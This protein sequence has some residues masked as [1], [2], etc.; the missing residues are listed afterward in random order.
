[1]QNSYFNLPII[2]TA[3]N[4]ILGNIFP[5]KKSLRITQSF[6]D[7]NSAMWYYKQIPDD[8]RLELLAYIE[9]GD[10]KYW[11]ILFYINNMV[12]IFDLPTNGDNIISRAHD[13]LTK[14]EAK[15]GVINNAL[16]RNSIQD[17][18]LTES[19]NNNE[20]YRT[21]RFIKTEYIS[22]LKGYLNGV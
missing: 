12:N 13:K 21:F 20:K 9:Y 6:I 4:Y 14:R 22:Q 19:F 15:F 16:L 5:T 10:S 2:T 17:E 7:N 1:M 11:D 8:S 18:Y 3:E